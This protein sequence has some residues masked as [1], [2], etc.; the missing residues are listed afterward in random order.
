MP[1]FTLQSGHPARRLDGAEAAPDDADGLTFEFRRPGRF[2]AI[3]RAAAPLRIAGHDGVVAARLRPGWDGTLGYS[4]YALEIEAAGADVAHIRL[5]AVP[6]PADTTAGTEVFAAR[7]SRFPDEPE[8]FRRWQT[9]YRH[10]LAAW[11]MAGGLP[12]R[13]PLAPELMETRQSPAFSLQRVRYR[14]REDRTNTLLLALPKE[15]PDPVPLLVALHGHEATWGEADAGAFTAGHADDFCAAFAERGWAVVQP[16]TMDH[17]LQHA[18]WTLQ[19]EWTWDAMAA[20]DYALA[21]PVID[22]ERVAVCGLS[23]GA[24]LAMNML[25]L[26]DRVRA[27]VVGCIL[28]T[29]HHYRTRMRIP[30]HRDCG[31]LGQLG[32]KLEPCDWAA[33]AAPK[34]VQFQHGRQDASFCPGAAPALLQPAWNTAVMPE[35]E[36]A[37]AFAEVERAWRLAGAEEAVALHTH[38]QGHRVDAAAALAFRERQTAGSRADFMT[39][40]TKDGQHDNE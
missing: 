36:F 38:A 30:P 39:T 3:L 12:A 35:A 31:I 16:A 21:Q 9:K 37:A 17:S 26:D 5:D 29:W 24:H 20:L 32:D 18:D 8:A 15:A 1:I 19:G 22:A 23:T 4:L 25:A 2:V 33:L 6:V 40:T 14:S 34:P 13:V 11:L 28:S 10:T 7:P 27:G